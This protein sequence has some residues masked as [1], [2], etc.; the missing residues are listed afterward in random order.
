MKKAE[1]LSTRQQPVRVLGGL[2]MLIIGIILVAVLVVLV[3]VGSNNTRRILTNVFLYCTMA[4]MW[5]LLSGFTGMTS[6]G[7]QTFVGVAGYSMAVMVT[8]YGMSYIVGWIV[9]GAIGAVLALVLSLILFRMRGMYF[10]IATWVIAEALKTWF[11]SWGFVGKG[12]G[13]TMAGRPD[14]TMVCL[15]ALILCVAAIVLIYFLL[16]SKIGLGLTAMRDDADAASSVGVN[17][18]RSKLICFV[19]AGL[20]CALAGGLYYRYNGTILPGSGFDIEWTVSLVFIVIIGGIGT[21][22]GP[23]VGTIVYI[24]LDEFLAQYSGWSN[25]I[26]GLIAILV[27]LFRMRGMYFA[28]ATWVVA[29]AIKTFFSSWKYVNMGGGMTV[30]GR[31][32][33]DII[34]ILSLVLC[35]VAIVLIYALL[36]S[37]LGLGLTAMRDDADAASSVGVN[38]FK[39][40]LICFVIAGLFCALAG[41]LYYLNNVSIYP[42]N[43][44]GISWTVS[45]VF[46]VIIGGIG[47]MAG[48]IVGTVV[49]IALDEVLASFPGWSNIILGAIAILV[50]LFLPDGILGTLQKK[51]HFEV[52]SQKR[53]SKE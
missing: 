4:C 13:M 45:L 34:F 5:N 7:Q 3:F 53:F 18:F 25:I 48:P 27:I 31:P 30:K 33:G 16:N 24:A 22:A 2:P 39:S 15:L 6:L 9:G 12:G 36:N 28:I 20:F 52:L 44:F 41:G 29:E 37:R 51:F 19:I 47:T 35:V 14:R 40:K 21:M 50:I 26:L 49:Y 8:T 42:N 43:G 38:I 23:I 32:S 11:T 46:I 17:I 10:A 1:N